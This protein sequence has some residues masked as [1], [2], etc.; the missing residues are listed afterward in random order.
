MPVGREVEEGGKGNGA[1][2]CPAAE[3]T[4]SH[5]LGL[6]FLSCRWESLGRSQGRVSVE[7]SSVFQVCSFRVMVSP[8]WSVTGQ[9]VFSHC[10]WFWLHP[11]GYAAFLGLDLNYNRGL[12]DISREER[13][14]EKRLPWG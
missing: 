9:G 2:C 13:P 10:T 14:E 6:L 8:D 1:G 11:P 12:D 7:Y 5:A 4:G 3:L